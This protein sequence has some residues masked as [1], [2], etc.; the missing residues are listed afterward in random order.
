MTDAELMKELQDVDRELAMLEKLKQ[1]RLEHR[2]ELIHRNSLNKN[3]AF[4]EYLSQIDL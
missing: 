3:A 2:R 4:T 1:S